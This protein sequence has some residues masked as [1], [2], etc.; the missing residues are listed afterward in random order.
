MEETKTTEA[1]ST[2]DASQ[3]NNTNRIGFGPRFGA[4]LIDLVL[5]SIV[6]SA[7]GMVLGATI[8]GIVFGTQAGTGSIEGD[9][10]AGGFGA[11]LGGIMGTLAGM[12]LMLLLLFVLEG[13][14]GQ[15]PGKM[16]L[17]I[18]NAN[19]DGTTANS[20]VLWMRALLK[21]SGTI[22]ALLAGVTGIAVL[23]SIGS[24]AG[25]AVFVGCFFALGDKKQAL[26]DM[27]A[28]TIVLKKEDIK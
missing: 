16:L 23:S 3:N 24:L 14:T 8:V 5:S 20:S 6:G 10:I 9:A 15:T 25:L 1:N 17:K 7:L 22:L 21:Y 27:V 28:K 26:H 19:Q 18:K 12:Y 13:I 2:M 11:M 4:Y